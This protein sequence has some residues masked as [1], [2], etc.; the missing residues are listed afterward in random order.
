[1]GI[2]KNGVYDITTFTKTQTI[3][4]STAEKIFYDKNGQLFYLA[5]STLFANQ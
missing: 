4:L 1:V 5:D 2:G 3:N